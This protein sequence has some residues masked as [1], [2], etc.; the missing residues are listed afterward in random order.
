MGEKKQIRISVKDKIACL[1]DEE[2]FLVCGNND[3]E[4]VFDF[5]SDWEGINAKTAVFVYGDTPIHQPFTD[6]I[7]EGVEIRNATLCAI[8]VFAGDIKTTT[9]AVIECKTSIRDLGGVPKPPSKEVY[10]KIMDLLNEAISNVGMT[11]EEKAEL[12]AK[13][14][15]KVDKEIFDD[16]VNSITDNQNALA[17]KQN[18]LT[19]KQTDLEERVADLESL[20]LTY[21]KDDATAYEKFAPAECGSRVQIKSIGGATKVI[22]KSKNIL[23]PYE[24]KIKAFDDDQTIIPYTVNES[25][26]ITFTIENLYGATLNLYDCFNI[27]ASYEYVFEGDGSDS[28]RGTIDFFA[29]TNEDYTKFLLTTFEFK[30]MVYWAGE[31]DEGVL[32]EPAREKTDFEPYVEPHFKHAEVERVDTLEAKLLNLKV[33]KSEPSVTT[34]GAVNNRVFTPNTYVLGMTVSN[35]YVPSYISSVSITDN[36]IAFTS[37]SPSYGIAFPLNLLPN[38]AYTLSCKRT[39]GTAYMG[40]SFYDDNGKFLKYVMTREHELTKTF[41][42]DEYAKVLITFIAGASNEQTIFSDIMLN[43]VGADGTLIQPQKLDSL[44]IPESAR[45]KFGIDDIDYDYLRIVDGRVEKVEVCKEIVLD[46]TEKMSVYTTTSRKGVRFE[47][48][49]TEDYNRAKGICTDSDKVGAY[50]TSTDKNFIWIGLNDGANKQ[51]I[52]WVDILDVL[53]FSEIKD[54]FDKYLKNRYESGNPV[55]IIYKRNEPNVTDVTADIIAANPKFSDP[56]KMFKL[57]IEGGLGR[58]RFVNEHEMP[59]PNTVWYVKR[60]E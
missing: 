40:A 23:N 32:I 3:Y 14:A 51:A 46:G 20:S 43:Q 15:N 8:G 55:R 27:P 11:E 12:E 2:Q 47:N 7:C 1:V 38:T 45:C 4:V 36:E 19:E 53:G 30:V 60:K 59:L 28:G 6:N 56:K 41:T 57:L 34:S 18:E 24:I 31:F 44:E 5:D 49:L 21:T 39:V 22:G 10:D 17:E 16:A 58:T 13:L 42:T 48:L 35:T 37:K 33:P 9:G 54:Q 25:G 26:L 29:N 50:S 52:F